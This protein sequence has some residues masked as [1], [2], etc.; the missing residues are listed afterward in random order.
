[1]ASVRIETVTDPESGQ[2]YAEVYSGNN[3]AP[4]LRSEPAFASHDGLVDQVLQMCRTHFPDHAPF[5]DDP[6]IGV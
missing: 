4:V 1:M 6:T 2:V 5:A 3:A